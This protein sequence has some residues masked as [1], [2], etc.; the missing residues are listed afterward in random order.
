MRYYSQKTWGVVVENM[1]IPLVIKPRKNISKVGVIPLLIHQTYITNSV[2]H[3]MYASAYSWIENN[4]EFEYRFYDDD[5]CYRLIKEHFSEHVLQAYEKL[6]KGAFRAD[7]WRYCCLFIHGGVY[8]DID[9]VCRSP[10]RKLIKP[11]DTLIIP[12]GV[13]HKTF[14]YN[15]FIC[16]EPGNLIIKSVIDTAVEII[17]SGMKTGDSGVKEIFFSVF[18]NQHSTDID[19]TAEVFG[20]V[21][22]LGLGRALNKFLGNDLHAAFS[23]GRA[24]GKNRGIRILRFT[25][26][27]GVTDGFRRV[28]DTRYD[29]Y[30]EDQINS[31][32]G[33]WLSS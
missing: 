26:R 28:L 27:F 16:T 14:M 30:F 5:L 11:E 6:P 18:G 23:I 4:P 9:T 1:Q 13:L 15:A 29:G 24:K 2:P 21:G 22:P 33:H 19:R 3:R 25:K 32:G 20:I 17:H 10:L 8:A 31:G 7:F 12:R